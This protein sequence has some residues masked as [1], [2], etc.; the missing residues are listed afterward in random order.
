M[1]SGHRLVLTLTREIAFLVVISRKSRPWLL[2]REIDVQLRG[3]LQM[4]RQLGICDVPECGRERIAKGLCHKHYWRQRNR[5][6]LVGDLA[7]PEHPVGE[8]SHNAKLTAD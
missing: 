7:R 4:G 2:S 6:P 3:W 5:L 8:A 1:R